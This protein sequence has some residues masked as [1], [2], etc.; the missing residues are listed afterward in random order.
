MQD[1][2]VE[3][4]AVATSFALDGAGDLAAGDPTTEVLTA[5]LSSS[6]S[7]SSSLLG[8]AFIE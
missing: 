7:S 4:A 1:A 8:L 2:G 5:S 6:S 3:V